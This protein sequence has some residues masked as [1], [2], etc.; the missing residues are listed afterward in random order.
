MKS[1]NDEDNEEL[2]LEISDDDIVWQEE[3]QDVYIEKDEEYLFDDLVNDFYIFCCYM[4]A[5]LGFGKPTTIQ[6][7][8]IEFISSP[9]KKD[10]LI[11]AP[12]GAG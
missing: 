2:I 12:R 8:I 10:K 1:F 3:L 11:Q 4:F 5:R 9:S 7:M 6:K